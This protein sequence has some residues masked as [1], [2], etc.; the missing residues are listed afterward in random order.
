MA[1]IADVA[2]RREWREIKSVLVSERVEIEAHGFLHN[3]ATYFAE[4]TSADVIHQEIYGAIQTFEANLDFRPTVFIWPGV[5]FTPATVAEAGKA[6]YQVSFT[7]YA[8]R[9]L[10]FNWIPQGDLERRTGNPLLL[11]PRYWST[12]AYVNL[13]QAVK[14]GQEAADF[15]N[16]NRQAEM[17]WYN[18]YCPG[19]P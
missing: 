15:T 9:P 13:D 11:L 6:G 5:N 7:A 12:A 10:T 3:G 14:L 16:K 18:R 8:R 2:D 1:F 4:K 17:D 19:C